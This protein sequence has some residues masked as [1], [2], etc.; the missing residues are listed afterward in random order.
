MVSLSSEKLNFQYFHLHR[1][2]RMRSLF[3]GSG[4]VFKFPVQ[5]ITSSLTVALF[6]VKK[7]Q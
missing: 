3:A 1:L 5:Q 6:V 4:S 7:L 2:K